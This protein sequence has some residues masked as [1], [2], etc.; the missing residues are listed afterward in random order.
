[1]RTLIQRWLSLR[2]RLACAIVFV[3]G[4]LLP[5]YVPATALTQE[6][7]DIEQSQF[8]F[9]EEG[10]LMKSSSL[11]EQGA[12]LAYSQGLVHIVREGD[13]LEKLSQKYSISKETIVWANSLKAGAAL[14]PGEELL[15]L[16]VDGVVHTVKRGQTLKQIADLYSITEESIA[17]QNKVE[18]GFIVAGQQLII[19][20]GKPSKTAVAT[21]EELQFAK[22]FLAKN[23][24][25]PGGSKADLAT[26]TARAAV[27]IQGEMR[28]PCDSCF[29]TQYY[30]PGHY[31]VDIQQRGGGPILA[32]EAGTI[33]R[34]DIGWNGGYGNVLEIDHGNGLVTLYAHNKE[35]YV[36]VG[37]Q[38]S[39]GQ[40]IAWMGNTGLV[41]GPTGIHAHFEVRYNGVKKNPLLYLQ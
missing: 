32:A 8:L 23:L 16:P 17:R 4:A 26:E 31:A 12:R 6:E 28:M 24:T 36:K 33:I 29:F 39:R 25:L 13:N 11:T 27:P 37:D 1:M 21:T 30:H 34:A 41:H 35:V 2:I 5:P 18:G 14:H 19:P 3:I 20:G 15:I 38:V 22:K 9:V 10:F 40:K 7:Q